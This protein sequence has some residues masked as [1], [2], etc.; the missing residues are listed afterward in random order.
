MPP[1]PG[2]RGCSDEVPALKPIRQLSN[3]ESLTNKYQDSVQESKR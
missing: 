1:C 2:C 3:D